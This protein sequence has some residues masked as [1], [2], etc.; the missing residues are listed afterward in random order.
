MANTQKD[1]AQ[2]AGGAGGQ[3]KFRKLEEERDSANKLAQE[4]QQKASSLSSSLHQVSS[5]MME[6]K[7]R[8][9]GL[10]K[11]NKELDGEIQVGTHSC[12]IV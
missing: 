5:L 9:E 1:A 12:S 10:R 8:N 2:T 3:E 7:N 6:E 4:C 11:L